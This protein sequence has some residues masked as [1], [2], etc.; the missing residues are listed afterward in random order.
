MNNGVYRPGGCAKCGDLG[1]KGRLP[2]LETLPIMDELRQIIV[3]GGSAVEIKKRALELGMLTLRRVGILN[4]IKK[5]TTIEEV[6]S[7]TMPDK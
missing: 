4:S 6:L 7:I 2:L 1:Y 3:K 5:G